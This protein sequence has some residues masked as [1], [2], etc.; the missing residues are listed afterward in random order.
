MYKL[1]A[2]RES[3][4]VIVGTLEKFNP[5]IQMTGTKAWRGEVPPHIS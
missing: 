4:K 5:V 3:Q 1:H 2:H